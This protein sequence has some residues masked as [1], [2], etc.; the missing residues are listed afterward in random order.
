[1]GRARATAVAIR[2][3]AHRARFLAWT[4]HLEFELRRRG[5]RLE[6]D[7]PHGLRFAAPPELKIVMAGEGNGTLRLSVGRDVTLGRHVQLEVWAP[8]TNVLEMHDD[9]Y[10]LD[11]VRLSLRSGTISLGARTNIR[12]FAVLKS[13]GQLLLGEE[14]SVSY[15]CVLHC[16]ERIELRDLVGMAERV[17]VIDSEKRHDGSD[18]HFLRQPLRVKPVVLERNVFVAANAVVTHGTHVGANSV[19]G[20][21]AVLTG[22]DY[23]GGSIIA[24]APAKPVRTLPGAAADQPAEV[25]SR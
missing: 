19:I 1:M 16:T 5:G 6:L 23:P 13:Q 3:S 25:S 14:V 11:G 10:T 15:G 4:A 20:A 8:G 7:A 22:G 9:S 21:C 2:D 17:T 18:T 24:G 12:D